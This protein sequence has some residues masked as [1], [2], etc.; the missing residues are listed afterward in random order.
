MKYMNRLMI[1]R[2]LMSIEECHGSGVRMYPFI[3][4]KNLLLAAFVTKGQK[5]NDGT[6]F[7]FISNL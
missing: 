7:S 5:E 6:R 2:S 3:K 1:P 4:K